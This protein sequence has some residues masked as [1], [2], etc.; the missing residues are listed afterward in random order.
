AGTATV[1]APNAGTA[2]VN[3][4]NAGTATVNAPNIGAAIVD[5]SDTGTATGNALHTGTATRNASDTGTATRNAPHTGKATRNASDTGTHTATGDGTRTAFEDG[6][7]TETEGGTTTGDPD[8]NS[9]TNVTAGGRTVLVGDDTGHVFAS[10]VREN[11]RLGD[12]DASDERLHA[13][14]RRVGLGEWLAGLPAGLDTW[15]GT[16]GSTVSG[17]Q[18]RRLA[19]ARALLADPA[20]LILDEP[21]EGIDEDGAHRL[22]ADLLGAADGRTVLVFAHRVEGFGLADRVLRLSRGKLTDITP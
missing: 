11:L 15:L 21:T 22:M 17:G 14:L 8:G 10:T 18:R 19:T 3:A 5:A 12:R 7:R 2:T 6:T 9:T 4:P 20:L 13:V 1:N 16:G